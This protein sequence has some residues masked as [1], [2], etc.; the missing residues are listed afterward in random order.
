MCVVTSS[1]SEW[2]EYLKS[3]DLENVSRYVVGGFDINSDIGVVSVM[4]CF[5]N[6]FEINH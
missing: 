5:K 6:S 1:N 3:G 4:D 2:R